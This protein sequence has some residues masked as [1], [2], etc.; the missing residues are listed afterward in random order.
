MR[1]RYFTFIALF[2]L[3]LTASATRPLRGAFNR[4]QSDGTLVRVTLQ[5]NAFF[6]YFLST[7]GIALLPN[8]DGDL[9][10]AR[11]DATGQVPVASEVLAHN[12]E[13]RSLEEKAF[14]ANSRAD[15]VTIARTRAI[16]LASQHRR[17]SAAPNPDGTCTYGQRSAGVCGS[18]GAPVIPVIMVYFPNRAFQDTTTVDK[19]SRLFNEPGYHDERY[20]NGSIKDYFE[21][22]SGGLYRPSF[23]VVGVVET[24]LGYEAYGNRADGGTVAATKS[25]LREALDGAVEQGVSF[26]EFKDENGE[27]PLVSIYYAGPGAHS[28]KEVGAEKYIWAHFQTVANLKVQ[29]IPVNGCFVGNELLQSYDNPNAAS[30]KVT[31]AQTDGIGVFCHEFGH[32]LGLPDFYYTGSNSDITNSLLSMDFWSVMDYGQYCY[33][34]YRPLGFNAYERCMLG[35]QKIVDLADN[36]VRHTLK[37]YADAGDEDVSCY[38]IKNPQNEREYFLLENRQTGT[39]YPSF[40]GRGMLITHVDYD[41]SAWSS[42]TLNNTPSHQRFTYVPADGAKQGVVDGSNF[43]KTKGDLYPGTE[44]VTEFSAVSPSVEWGTFFTGNALE[45]ALYHIR[46]D[47]RDVSFAFNNP[48]LVGIHAPQTP[49][50]ASAVPAAAYT[51]DGRRAAETNAPGIRIVRMSDGTWRKQLR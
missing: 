45:D 47:G 50:D 39:W 1:N 37:A 32:A 51:L 22:Q 38:R 21:S 9:C 33:D 12:P 34:G 8:A 17:A 19:I 40:M 31:G 2:L 44:N 11:I 4:P 48:D 26:E 25:L 42:N 43:D 10:Y 24:M 6:N 30:P 27:I 36:S 20:C 49:G 23:K 46:M 14:V 28:A 16:R 15:I 7:D 29:G 3:V 5:G 41:A 13:G 18:I 35:W